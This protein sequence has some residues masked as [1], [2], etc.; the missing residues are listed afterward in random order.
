MDFQ[1]IIINVLE[2]YYHGTDFAN[3]C[4]LYYFRFLHE[5]N[6]HIAEQYID[7]MKRLP[8]QPGRIRARDFR[9][10]ARKKFNTEKDRRRDSDSRKAARKKATLKTNVSIHLQRLPRLMSIFRN[11]IVLQKV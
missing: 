9:E 6:Q 3:L 4:N 8:I 7:V 2:L 11:Q 1:A 5:D 10:F